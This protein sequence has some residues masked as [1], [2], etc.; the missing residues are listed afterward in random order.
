MRNRFASASIV[1]L[2]IGSSCSSGLSEAD[3]ALCDAIYLDMDW[4][5]DNVRV[6]AF[7]NDDLTREEID[8]LQHDIEGWDQVDEAEF[9]S[10][11]QALDE[12][13]RLFVDQQSLIDVVEADPSI[14]PASLRIHPTEAAGYSAIADR[15]SAI[16]GIREVSAADAAVD[17]LA[18]RFDSIGCE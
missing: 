7:L 11:A 8:A 13:K 6:M 16:P 14:L 18:A 1:L 9:F 2:L 17:A 3:R 10:K 12:F 15:L 5:V 4:W